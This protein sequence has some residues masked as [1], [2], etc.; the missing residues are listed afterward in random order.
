M[1]RVDRLRQQRERECKLRLPEKY[2]VKG[3]SLFDRARKFGI[4][5]NDR[6]TGNREKRRQNIKETIREERKKVI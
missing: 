4:N 1:N 2:I 3:E 6:A 5:P